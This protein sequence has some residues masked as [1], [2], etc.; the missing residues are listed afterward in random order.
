MDKKAFQVGQTVKFLVPTTDD[1]A[2]ERFIVREL[3]GPRVLVE[4]MCDM[5]I[6]P[7][8]VYLASDLVDTNDGS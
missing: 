7:T 8:F 3:R 6:R 4:Y 5:G 2:A 1:E